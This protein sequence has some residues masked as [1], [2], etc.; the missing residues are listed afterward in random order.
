MY[1]RSILVM[2][3]LGQ[4]LETLHAASSRKF[5]EKTVLM[6]DDQLIERLESLH[7]HDY[8]HR[9]V[10]VTFQ[11]KP[12]M[13]YLA[14]LFIE[15]IQNKS[16]EGAAPYRTMS[17][18]SMFCLEILL[19]INTIFLYYYSI[20]SMLLST[21]CPCRAL[22]SSE[23]EHSCIVAIFEMEIRV[24]CHKSGSRKIQRLIRVS[25][26][27]EFFSKRRKNYTF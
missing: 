8:I 6:I 22:H 24:N 25:L 10:E 20:K 14:P 5:S 4:S 23:T 9:D 26:S 27:T 16:E 2:E 7:R 3:I 11:H 19:R 12:K 15:Y 1:K 17:R 18:T 13:T 21:A